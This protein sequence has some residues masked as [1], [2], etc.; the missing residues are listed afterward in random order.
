[1]KSQLKSILNFATTVLLFFTACKAQEATETVQSA[2][3]NDAT[4]T[5]SDSTKQE[6]PEASFSGSS[7]EDLA[8]P[9]FRRIISPII[10]TKC[11]RCHNERFAWKDIRLDSYEALVENEAAVKLS[12]KNGSENFELNVIEE[13]AINTWYT[14]GMPKTEEDC[15]QSFSKK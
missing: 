4:P 7:C 2:A 15:E 1:M 6:S 11:A 12:I 14:S 5:S 10:E 9:S 13:N 3:I 8:I